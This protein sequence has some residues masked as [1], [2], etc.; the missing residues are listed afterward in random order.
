MP[1]F[2]I[3]AGP[4]FVLPT[5]PTG[6]SGP[7]VTGPTGTTGP[8]GASNFSGYT[9]SAGSNPG[10]FGLVQGLPGFGD[11]VVQYGTVSFSVAGTTGTFD[12][13]FPNGVLAMVATPNAGVNDAFSVSSV[14]KTGFIGKSTGTVACYYIAI[15]Y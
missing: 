13:P 2:N 9:G 14:T 10:F 5:G 6:P 1:V 12:I 15:G 11:F 3:K 4:L 8:T 7:G